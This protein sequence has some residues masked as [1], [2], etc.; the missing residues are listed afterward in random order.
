MVVPG[1]EATDCKSDK[2]DR[3][4]TSGLRRAWKIDGKPV[5]LNIQIAPRQQRE[6]KFEAVKVGERKGKQVGG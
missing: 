3:A 5:L 6:L 1:E 2:Q 4:G